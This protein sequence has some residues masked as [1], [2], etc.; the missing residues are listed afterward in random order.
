MG[1]LKFYNKGL[2]FTAEKGDFKI[3]RNK[4]RKYKR[5]DLRKRY[6]NNHWLQKLSDK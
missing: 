3:Y 5:D 2:E 4:L 6:M 1:S